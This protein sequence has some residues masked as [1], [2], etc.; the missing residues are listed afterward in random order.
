[1]G[2]GW[3][4]AFALIAVLVLIGN[5]ACLGECVAG[6]CGLAKAPT[7]RCHHHKSSSDE[8]APCP[9]QHNEFS[10]PEIG[11]AKINIVSSVAAI[12]WPPAAITSGLLLTPFCLKPDVGSPPGPP[13]LSQVSVLRI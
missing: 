1:M 11:I 6:G 5:A 12:A 10:S 13:T 2:F 8:T 9:H 4:R 3:S 7:S